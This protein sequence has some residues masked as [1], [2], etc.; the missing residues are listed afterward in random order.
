[1]DRNSDNPDEIRTRLERL[2]RAILLLATYAR[3][4]EGLQTLE[5]ALEPIRQRL[6]RG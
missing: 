5:Q 4:R 3:D 1:V 2:E 6:G